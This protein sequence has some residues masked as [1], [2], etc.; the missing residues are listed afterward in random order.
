MWKKCAE[1]K[2]GT[3]CSGEDVGYSYNDAV[4]EFGKKTS[5]AGHNDWRL[6]SI[7]ELRSL[8]WCSNGVDVNE[9]DSRPP[10]VMTGCDHPP[11]LRGGHTLRER[12]VGEY[13]EPTIDTKM[14]PNTYNIRESS[15]IY[16]FWSGSSVQHPRYGFMPFCIRFNAGALDTSGD[17]NTY[18]V[19]LVRGSSNTR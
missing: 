19:R 10:I 16:T 14:F 15:E 8:V 2:K 5:F 17:F 3:E 13:K 4:A 12:K 7:N 1:G 9:Q 11:E 6:P 18:Q